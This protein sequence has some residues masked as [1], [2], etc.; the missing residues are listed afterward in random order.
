MPKKKDLKRLVRARMKKTGESY[1]AA[2]AQLARTKPNGGY[3]AKP[4]AAPRSSWAALAGHSD[5]TIREKTGRTWAEWVALLDE[6]GAVEMTHGEIAKS[7]RAVP[8]VSGWWSQ[9]VAVGYERIRGIRAR[10]QR[11]DGGFSATKS[12]T[13][14]VPIATLYAAFSKKPRRRRWLADVDL[15]V[16][17][18][19]E[20]KTLRMSS[21]D[22]TSVAAYFTASGPKKSVLSVEQGKLASAAAVA[23]AKAAWAAR[24][25]ALAAFLE[26]G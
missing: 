5:A 16:R 20:N 25:D 19:V 17:T 24:F 11:V 2:R 7:A 9:T 13:F 1:T 14:R 23:E 22:G 12:R 3:R 26:P 18:G 4:S 15:T 6:R 8:G 21:A 10:Y